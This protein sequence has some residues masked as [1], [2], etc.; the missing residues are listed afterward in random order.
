[1][2]RLDRFCQPHF[3]LAQFLDLRN[4]IEQ[5]DHADSPRFAVLHSMQIRGHEC[6]GARRGIVEPYLN[7]LLAIDCH[8]IHRVQNSLVE[9]VHTPKGHEDC[10]EGAP[11]DL[12]MAE[13]QYA[14]RRRVESH[15]VAIRVKRHDPAVH[16][17]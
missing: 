14:G 9:V 12:V 16:I 15:D 17:V 10:G 7:H 6:E 13:F 1:M 2:L 11:D 8:V 5:D 3:G 4:V